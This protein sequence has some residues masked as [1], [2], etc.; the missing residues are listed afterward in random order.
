[1]ANDDDDDKCAYSVLLLLFVFLLILSF[2]LLQ[3]FAITMI[4]RCVF[5]L[6]KAPREKDDRLD[7]LKE[8]TFQKSQLSMTDNFAKYSKLERQIK[9]IET[10]LHSDRTQKSTKSFA[11]RMI[12]STLFKFLQALSCMV[13]VVYV[14]KCSLDILDSSSLTVLPDWLQYEFLVQPPLWLIMP[15]WISICYYLVPYVTVNLV[16]E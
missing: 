1:M 6:L 5:F 11:A 7:R 12:L 9:K 16:S 8:L 3:K 10:E 15:C 13:T 4:I 14:R 2:T